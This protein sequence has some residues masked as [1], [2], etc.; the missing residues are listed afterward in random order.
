MAALQQS[1]GSEG[2]SGGLPISDPELQ[3][4]RITSTISVDDYDDT[5]EKRN[6]CC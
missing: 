2:I 5:E 6:Q 4:W 3:S 1:W